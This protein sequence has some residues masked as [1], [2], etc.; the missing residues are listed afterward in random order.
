MNIIEVNAKLDKLAEEQKGSFSLEENKLKTIEGISGIIHGISRNNRMEI[1]KNIGLTYMSL[2][3]GKDTVEELDLNKLFSGVF[4]DGLKLNQDVEFRESVEI[5]F[6]NTSFAICNLESFTELLMHDGYN[7]HFC[8]GVISSMLSVA[9]LFNIDFVEAIESF[10]EVPETTNV[11]KENHG[12]IFYSLEEKL[13]DCEVISIVF[14]DKC[15]KDFAI[16]VYTESGPWTFNDVLTKAKENGYKEGVITVLL[17]DYRNGYVF[18]FGNYDK[19][20][21]YHVG[22]TQGFA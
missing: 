10:M 9:T 1:A 4:K 19:E 2:Y 17:E 13:P 16:N 3:F 11:G 20:K 6:S 14:D 15:V 22:I 8:F 5:N 21:F 18:N 12:G 7:F